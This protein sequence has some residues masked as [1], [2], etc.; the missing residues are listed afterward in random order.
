MIDPIDDSYDAL[1]ESEKHGRDLAK[2]RSNRQN[3][4]RM[5]LAREL[6]E[7]FENATIDMYRET[8]GN[9]KALGIARKVID[10]GFKLGCAFHGDEFGNGKTALAAAVAHAAISS[11]RGARFITMQG[12]VD[13]IKRAFDDVGKLQAVHH[14][15]TVD[16]LVLDDY[17]KD[18]STEFT[19]ALKYDVF[20]ARWRARKPMVVT[21]NKSVSELMALHSA[22]GRDGADDSLAG[23]IFDRILAMTGGPRGWVRVT[24][25]SQRWSA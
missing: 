18:Y 13:E 25:S 6:G 20:D 22:K 5:R 8:A 15:A 4:R 10:S 24:G 2:L 12:L 1:W 23:S 11:D 9:R 21:S 14:F 19:L 17:G 16:V 7:E 3:H